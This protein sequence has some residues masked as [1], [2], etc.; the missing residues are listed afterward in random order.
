MK[1]RKNAVSMPTHG[2]WGET[3]T[4]A[5]L[6]ALFLGLPLIFHDGYFDIT[7]AKQVFFLASAG[8]YLFGMLVIRLLFG[9]CARP[10]RRPVLSMADGC[11]LALLLI[12]VLSSALSGRFGAALLGALDR[13]QGVLTVLLYA[14]VYFCVSRSFRWTRLNDAALA[15]G[16]ALCCLLALLNAFSLD[17]L[18]IRAVLPAWVRTRYISAIGN[19]DFFGAYLA[20]AFPFLLA[21]YAYAESRADKL[22]FA[23]SLLL[24]APGVALSGCESFFLAFIAAMVLLPLL[25]GTRRAMQRAFLASGALL[26]V[27]C[28]LL[29]LLPPY[30]QG[31]YVS[32]WMRLLLQ[33]TVALPLA[34]LCFALAFALKSEAA[35][36]KLTRAYRIA[37]LS[38]CALGAAFLLLSNTLL[39]DTSF[40][41]LDRFV[42][43]G[44][45][46]GT[47]R[48]RIWSRCVAWYRT[49]PFLQ[50]LI[51]GG[52]GVVYALDSVAP[53]F[54]DA[55]MDSAHNEY[56]HLLL[57]TGICGLLAYLGL[58]IGALMPALRRMRGNALA[59]ACAL[60]VLA[61]AVQAAVNIA[62]PF[63]TPLLY[64]YLA[65]LAGLRRSAAP[66]YSPNE[67]SG[68]TDII[69]S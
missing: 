47:D 28:A 69:D 48:G 46:W 37:L 18:G 3:L 23:A 2:L 45:G 33:P 21:R 39:R 56:L 31:L 54:P 65:A 27:L 8:M 20:A 49:Y 57:T 15:L 38:A 4:S 51:G 7:E 1:L 63:S 10:I 34:L 64:A 24:A 36:P 66:S 50:K 25:C 43:F 41:T 32:Y 29:P 58:L 14:G 53:L 52:S 30:P 6:A 61:Y 13:Y 16:C 22:L 17:P 9:G 62:Q 55:V 60:S 5:Y 35:Y 26:A 12:V 44:T 68:M 40:G 67:L 59:M 19:I 11:I 42:K